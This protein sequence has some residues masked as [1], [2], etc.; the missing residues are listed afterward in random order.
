MRNLELQDLT[1]TPVDIETF[2]KD[3]N[4]LGNAFTE[5]YPYWLDVLKDVYADPLRSR[6]TDVILAGSLGTGRSYAVV[7]GFLYDLYILTL[8]KNPHEKWT[9]IPTTPID[10]AIFVGN[11]ENYFEDVVLDALSISPYFRS[12]LL[13]G[14]GSILEEN[15]FPNNIGIIT[16]S[17]R[18]FYIGRA[19]V[20]AIFDCE[21]EDNKEGSEIAHCYE[22][23]RRRVITRFMGADGIVPCRMWAVS[24]SSGLLNSFLKEHID[25]IR[26]DDHQK[27]VEPYIWDVNWHKGVYSG[28]TFTVFVGDDTNEPRILNDDEI[29]DDSYNGRVIRVPVEYRKDFVHDVYASLLDLAGIPVQKPMPQRPGLT[30]REEKLEPF[31][32]L[33]K[34]DIRLLLVFVGFFVMFVLGVFYGMLGV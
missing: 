14:K 18:R 7:A 26:F 24:S 20:G 3:P 28:D 19:I 32:F 29:V 27:V 9:L 13:P 34:K 15:M 8:V 5:I 23:C 17:C 6:Y 2:I 10:M 30:Y 22:N 4:Y 25:A 12:T 1:S 31:V 21:V 16:A 33:E 11:T